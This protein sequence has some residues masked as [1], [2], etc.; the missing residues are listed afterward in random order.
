MGNTSVALLFL[1][2]YTPQKSELKKEIAVLF[3]LSSGCTFMKFGNIRVLIL[4]LHQNF[5]ITLFY[6]VNYPLKIRCIV[7]KNFSSLFQ[8]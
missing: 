3:W 2:Q 5:A 8:F 4:Y 7:I 6:T 1:V